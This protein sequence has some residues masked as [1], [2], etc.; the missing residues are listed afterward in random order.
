MKSFTSFIA[1]AVFATSTLGFPVAHGPAS[2]NV[3]ARASSGKRG[4]SFN[5][6]TLTKDFNSGQVSFAYNWDSAFQGNL[7][8]GVNY[9]PML[10]SAAPEHS[11]QWE[12]NA[13]AAIAAGSTHL[14]FINEPDLA[15]Q[16]NTSP[17]DAAKQWMQFMQPFHGKATLVS[18]AITNGA[19]PAMGTGWMDQF[20]SEC[21]KLGCSVDAIAAHVYDSATNAAY[22]QNYITELGTKYNRPVLI[23]EFGASG[24]V[25]QQQAFL[26]TMVPFLDG[27][28][29]VSHYAW[30]M[31]AVG[32]LVNADGSLTPLGQTYVSA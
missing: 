5:D 32:N 2:V 19:P 23:T 4:L 29:S 15:T 20:L 27:L 25:E 18:P 28:A 6:A 10:W 12:A 21:D 14:L 7:P 3:T 9:F 24:S 16:S 11:N 1:L 30:F 26:Q 17:A 13:N 31:T 22:Y 8:A